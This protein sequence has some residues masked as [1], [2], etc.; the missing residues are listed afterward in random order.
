[1]GSGIAIN[2]ASHDIKVTLVEN[3]LNQIEY[4][5]KMNISESIFNNMNITNDISQING[6][7]LVIEA[8]NE[9]LQKKKEIF[10]HLNEYISTD[11]IIASNTSGLS[12]AELSSVS[13]YPENVIGFHYFYPVDKMKLVEI[14]PSII[15]NKFVI[16]QMKTFS[17]SINKTPVM[18][19][20]YPGFLVNRV[21]VPMINEAI[22]CVMEGNSP[23][24]VD[25][26][27]KLGANH[28]M[29]P[30]TLADFVGLDTLLATMNGL[31]YGFKDSK[32]RPC[33]LLVKLVESGNLGKKTGS[34]FFNYN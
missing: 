29:G 1:M 28:P 9:D 23:E 30:I 24:E 26:A 13:K 17:D 8:V 2:A 12:I 4:I 27:L 14:A 6:S 19:K 15:T 11:T 10:S 18:S 5:K 25:K 7:E 16:E 34:G 33:P 22:F 20:D 32:Y 31:Y 3:N 21:L